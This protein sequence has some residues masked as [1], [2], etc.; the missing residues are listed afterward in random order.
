MDDITFRIKSQ[1]KDEQASCLASP[2]ETS[3]D[4][5]TLAAGEVYRGSVKVGML[6]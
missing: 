5:P 2:L 4:V 1:R 3:E 6:A